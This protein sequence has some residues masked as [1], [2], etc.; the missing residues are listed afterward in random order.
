MSAA[1]AEAM[2][3]PAHQRGTVHPPEDCSVQAPGN[4]PRGI[5]HDTLQKGDQYLH[6]PLPVLQHCKN[7]LLAENIPIFLCDTLL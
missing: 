5:S 6:T 2:Q 1:A 4:S 7:F 3:P